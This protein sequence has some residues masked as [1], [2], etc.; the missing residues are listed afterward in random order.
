MQLYEMCTLL[1]HQGMQIVAGAWHSFLT[2][3][4]A[5]ITLMFR[6]AVLALSSIKDTD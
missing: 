5:D 4:V 2:T 6:S 3:T 1:T